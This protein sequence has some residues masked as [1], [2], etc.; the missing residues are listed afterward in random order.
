MDQILDDQGRAKTAAST[1]PADLAAALRQVRGSLTELFTALDVDPS[2]PREAARRLGVNK[3]LTWKVSKIIA[4]TNAATIVQHLPGPSGLD[5]LLA[6]C[7]RAGASRGA[8]DAVREALVAFDGLVTEHAGDRAA[9]MLM[10]NSMMQGDRANAELR[11]AARKKSFEGNSVTWGVQAR[12]RLAAH[13]VAPT[14]NDPERIDAVL[15]TGLIDLGRL[16]P[17]ASWPLFRRKNYN[18]DGTPIELDEDPIDP[19][20]TR[21]LPLI[22]EFCSKPLIDVSV[23]ADEFETRYELPPGPIGRTG[24]VSCL[25]GN[26]GR[27]F[28]SRYR[29][30]VNLYGEHTTTL[31]TPIEYAMIDVLLHRDLGYPPPRA[32]LYSTLTTNAPY[33]QFGRERNLLQISEEIEELGASPPVVATPLVADYPRLI[34]TVYERCGWTAADF[35]GYRFVMRYPPIPTLIVLR[36]DLPERSES[37]SQKL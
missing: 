30:D 4:A 27:G 1:L 20:A 11:E 18:D 17:D 8:A 33:P 5:I 22:R 23:L 25:I 3:N 24:A 6:A 36:Y 2:T 34:E 21:E 32:H 29:D 12:V 7:T 31:V 9:L 28:A 14:P 35:V 10:L 26:W 16:R 15:V 13:F 19:Q 37:A